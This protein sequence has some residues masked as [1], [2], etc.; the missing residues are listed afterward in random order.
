MKILK[1][2]LRLPLDGGSESFGEFGCVR[3]SGT[4][5]KTQ[6]R[7]DLYVKVCI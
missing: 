6:V 5:E 4:I 3:H 2:K 1:R 7:F